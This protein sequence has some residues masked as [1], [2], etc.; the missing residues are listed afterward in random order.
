MS[1]SIII[2]VHTLM[3]AQQTAKVLC[4]R[5]VCAQT[6]I[7]RTTI[8]AAIKSG[9]LIARKWGRRTVVLPDDLTN[10]LKQLP[11]T[12]HGSHQGCSLPVS[13]SKHDSRQR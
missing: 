1:T 2:E 4:I 5:D 6:G 13:V 12:R 10:F 7:G 8:Y 9:A 11:A 3:N